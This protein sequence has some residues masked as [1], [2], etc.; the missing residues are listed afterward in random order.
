MMVQL[1]ADEITGQENVPDPAGILDDVVAINA[2]GAVEHNGSAAGGH[3]R[4]S[5]EDEETWYKKILRKLFEWLRDKMWER[6]KEFLKM[7]GQRAAVAL[8][9]VLAALLLSGAH[10]FGK[11]IEGLNKDKG[12]PKLPPGK[13]VVPDRPSSPGPQQPP[14]HVPSAPWN[15][16]DTSQSGFTFNDAESYDAQSNSFTRRFDIP[17]NQAGGMSVFYDPDTVAVLQP[18]GT[19]SYGGPDGGWSGNAMDEQ[20]NNIFGDWIE[21][22]S[23]NFGVG[24]GLFAAW[25]WHIGTGGTLNAQDEQ[26]IDNLLPSWNDETLSDP[27]LWSTINGQYVYWKEIQKLQLTGQGTGITSSLPPALRNAARGTVPGTIVIPASLRYTDPASVSAPAPTS[28]G[29]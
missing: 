2:G 20:S 27:A 5:D 28:G 25:Y 21:E 26:D 10:D 16:P 14:A 11:W 1:L 23:G 6:V 9:G 7:I 17:K 12:K 19:Y 8:A 22:K 24:A 3:K 15:Q 18:G 13:P 4:Q 29:K